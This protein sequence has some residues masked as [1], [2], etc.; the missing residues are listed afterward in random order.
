M[1]KEP[2]QPTLDVVFATYKYRSEE[3]ARLPGMKPIINQSN[4]A[5]SISHH[6]QNIVRH[7]GH[8]RSCARPA[9][10]E[11]LLQEVEADMPASLHN[12]F[13]SEDLCQRP[14]G[15][16][17]HLQHLAQIPCFHDR[18]FGYVLRRRSDWEMEGL[19]GQE[20]TRGEIGDY[21]CSEGEKR[22]ARPRVTHLG[23]VRNS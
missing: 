19:P 12:P 15:S 13:E 5:T 18:W 21:C 7:T 8:N 6:L 22:L 4:S 23:K 17:G 2:Y 9:R 3:H 10:E 1:R 11:R 14:L 16:I 20:A